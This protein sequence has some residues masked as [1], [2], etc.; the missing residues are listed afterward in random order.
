MKSLPEV[1]YK[2]NFSIWEKL[3][4]KCHLWI[5][6]LGPNEPFLNWIIYNVFYGGIVQ[7][8]L[9]LKKIHMLRTGTLGA[10]TNFF[11]KGPCAN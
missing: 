1:F 2:N 7:N 9:G 4:P 10:P 11:Y 8:F 3:L 5:F 6:A